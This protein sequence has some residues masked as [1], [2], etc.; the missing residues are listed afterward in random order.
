[1]AQYRFAFN[2]AEELIDAYEL[3]PERD[4]GE[5]S[6]TCLGCGEALIAKVKGEK[7]EKHFAH[8]A[9][10]LCSEE[11]YLHR[12]AKHVF[13]RTYLDCIATQQPFTITLSH[14]RL[15]EKYATLMGHACSLGHS[16]KQHDLTRY[17]DRIDLEKRDG[18]FIPD[19]KIY[20]SGNKEQKIY[21]EIAVTHFLSQEK[22]QSDHKIIE[23]PIEIEE[24]IVKITGR[25]LTEN[26]ASFI[27]FDRNPAPVVDAEC[28]CA[29]K[30]Y[31]CLF[32]Y[33]SHKSYLERAPL[34][35]LV[36]KH[37]KSSEKVVYSR[38]LEVDG[39]EHYSSADGDGF[40][41][42]RMVEEAAKRGFP[43]RNCFVC[44]YSGENYDSLSGK[45]IFCKFHKMTCHSNHAVDCQIYRLR[46]DL[47]PK[48]RPNSARP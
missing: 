47:T 41:Y 38:L 17:F 46:D 35:E 43:V 39:N 26:M 34:E 15:C 29:R 3:Q 4:S 10:A 44:Q 48:S 28:V 32:I 22:Q 18:S 23:I 31:L 24:D 19:L 30:E 8:K 5:K 1:M 14:P 20:R 9:H 42:V 40:Y 12:L 25:N 6:Y 45:P 16:T 13:Y 7:K 2:A 21:V 37:T 36:R 11:T 27:N 33:K